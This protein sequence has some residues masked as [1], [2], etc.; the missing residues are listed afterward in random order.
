MQITGQAILDQIEEQTYAQETVTG[1]DG[2]VLDLDALFAAFLPLAQKENLAKASLDVDGGIE[3]GGTTFSLEV[4]VINLPLRYTNQ[5]KKLVY[6][7]QDYD[8]QVYMIVD[9]PFVSKSRLQIAKVASLAALLDDH[10]GVFAKAAAWFDDQLQA[11]QENQKNQA[12]E[13]AAAAEA[14][15]AEAE[16][17][18]AEEADGGKA[19]KKAKKTT[20]K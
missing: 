13:A 20:K 18:K 9:N 6:A 8:L 17:E 14:E 16:A 19:T 3:E 7:D 15:K 10:E 4:N 2:Q 5:E 11:I 1:Q 12:E